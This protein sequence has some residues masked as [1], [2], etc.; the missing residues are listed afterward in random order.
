MGIETGFLALLSCALIGV[1]LWLVVRDT[2]G[3]KLRLPAAALLPDRPLVAPAPSGSVSPDPAAETS[4]GVEARHG[5][6]G[7]APSPQSLP[8][9]TADPAHI[10]RSDLHS[11]LRA[12]NGAFEPAGI[13]LVPE[14]ET[15]GG[16]DEGPLLAASVMLGT[17]RAGALQVVLVDH[18]VEVA[19]SGAQLDAG[20]P[21][22]RRVPRADASIPALAEAIAAC[23]WPVARAAQPPGKS[24]V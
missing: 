22:V 16:G 20:A 1:G 9:R 3:R 2:R 14:G 19:A 10:L 6:S 5:P 13:S 4:I 18:L 23:V 12:V 21:R 15:R 11:A 24:I 17:Q 8:A 7:S